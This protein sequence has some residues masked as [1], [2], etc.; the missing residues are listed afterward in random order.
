[1]EPATFEVRADDQA[2]HGTGSLICIADPR[3]A[4]RLGRL[5]SSEFWPGKRKPAAGSLPGG[6]STLALRA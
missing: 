5:A 4:V 6:L 2:Q 3:M 1:V